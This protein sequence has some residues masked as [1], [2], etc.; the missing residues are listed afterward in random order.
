MSSTPE[1]GEDGTQEDAIDFPD[2]VPEVGEATNGSDVDNQQD[3]TA[4]DAIDDPGDGPAVESR[5]E[6]EPQHRQDDESL[7]NEEGAVSLHR[8][9]KD[10]LR[11]DEDTISIPDDSPSVQV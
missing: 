2:E 6:D 8:N 1:E 9:I 5:E 4:T 11:S 10:H 3:S 7:V